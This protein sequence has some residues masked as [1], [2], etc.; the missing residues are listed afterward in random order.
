MLV[1]KTH[2]GHWRDRGK[3]RGGHMMLSNWWSRHA[4]RACSYDLPPSWDHSCCYLFTAER[5]ALAKKI[6][7]TLRVV[8]VPGWPDRFAQRLSL[9]NVW[10]RR[11]QWTVPERAPLT[12]VS[13]QIRGNSQ[14][15]KCLRSLQKKK[16]NSERSLEQ[17]KTT[18]AISRQ[19][20]S[21]CH[22]TCVTLSSLGARAR[23]LCA[24]TRM[25]TRTCWMLTHGYKNNCNQLCIVISKVRTD[26]I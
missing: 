21:L 14:R 19:D 11:L 17:K 26:E 1:C 22:V 4:N 8:S 24:R 5:G 18:R 12:R 7:N 10:T 6:Q 25:R 20:F 16:T 3:C 9:C 23:S 13:H 15:P 2:K